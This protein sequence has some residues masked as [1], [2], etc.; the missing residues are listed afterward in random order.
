MTSEVFKSVSSFQDV[1]DHHQPL[2]GG[3]LLVAI[4]NVEFP[5]MASSASP[6]ICLIRYGYL[7]GLN[8][9]L[10][11]LLLQLLAC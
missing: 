1:E 4:P 5:T 6:F 8:N 9:Q 11:K 10:N 7:I 2:Q 3:C